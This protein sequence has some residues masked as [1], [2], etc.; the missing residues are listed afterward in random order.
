V[1]TGASGSG[2]QDPM[3][4]IAKLIDER[5]EAAFAGRERKETEAKD[6]WARLEGM[7]DRKIGEHFEAFT[8]AVLEGDESGGGR[9][10]AGKGDEGDEGD[11]KILGILGL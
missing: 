6:P 9:A 8:K 3:E 5:L 4:K 10:K 11:G 7:I 2:K 1:A